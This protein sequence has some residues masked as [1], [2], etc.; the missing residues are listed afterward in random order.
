VKIVF[1]PT[2]WEQYRE[3]AAD[4][5][6]ALKRLNALIEEARRTPFAGTGKP[7]PLRDNLAGWWSRRIDREHRIVY[8]VAGKGEDQV[9][10][11]MQCRFHYGR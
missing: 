8:R 7:E 6:K 9:L 3:W 5:P 11:I 1:L 2:A 10:E 4:D